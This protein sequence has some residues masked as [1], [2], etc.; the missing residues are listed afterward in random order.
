MKLIIL[1]FTILGMVAIF[2]NPEVY[3]RQCCGGSGD[4]RAWKDYNKASV[5]TKKGTVTD[6]KT[7]DRGGVHIT[8]KTEKETIDV[9]LGP[10]S[11]LDN[12][13]KIAKGDAI[14]VT[15]SRV[16]YNGAAAIIAREIEKG[17]VK[18]RLRNDDGTPLWAGHGR[19]HK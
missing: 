13:M 11:F 18:V 2:S 15:G 19:R 9:H 8:L 3:A 10:A 6:L 17:G 4:G 12:K 14:S 1:S 16:T 7:Y 5:E